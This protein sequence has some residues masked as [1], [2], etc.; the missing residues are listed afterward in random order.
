MTS[1]LGHGFESPKAEN[2]ITPLLIILIFG[3]VVMFDPNKL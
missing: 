2:K 1:K 3:G